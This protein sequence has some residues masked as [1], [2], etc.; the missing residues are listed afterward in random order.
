MVGEIIIKFVISY[1]CKPHTLSNLWYPS[2]VIGH[3]MQ[4]IMKCQATIKILKVSFL[5]QKTT[6]FLPLLC[7]SQ[8]NV[9]P[10]LLN[11]TFFGTNR[12]KYKTFRVNLINDCSYMYRAYIGHEIYTLYGIR[13]TLYDVNKYNPVFLTIISIINFIAQF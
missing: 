4:H 3:F 1:L 9:H 8:E 6:T 7:I 10:F 13:Y 2:S 12:S 5:H 11:P